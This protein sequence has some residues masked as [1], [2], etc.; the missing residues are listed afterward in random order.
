MAGLLGK[1][2]E[3]EERDVEKSKALIAD[4]DSKKDKDVVL[5]KIKRK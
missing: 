4:S 5:M 1:A 3:K 2:A